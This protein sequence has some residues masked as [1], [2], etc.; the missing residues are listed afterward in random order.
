VKP[1]L[2]QGVAAIAAPTPELVFFVTSP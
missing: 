1:S 2:K